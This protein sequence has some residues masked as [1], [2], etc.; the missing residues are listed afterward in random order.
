MTCATALLDLDPFSVRL[1]T[2]SIRSF[3]GGQGEKVVLLHG[4]GGSAANWTEVLDRLVPG[5]R[6]L[7][8]DLPGHGGSDPLP[9]GASVDDYADAVAV[10]IDRRG[11]A[12]A[13]VVGHSFGGQ[14]ALRLAVRHPRLVQALLLVVSSGVASLPRRSAMGGQLTTALRP[15][16]WLAP[17][18][19]RYAGSTWFRM[20][21]FRPFL[22]ADAAAFPPRA[23]LGFFAELREHRDVRGAFRALL[24]DMQGDDVELG[25]P[26]IVVWGA[27]DGIVPVEHG[28][29]LARLLG[30]PLRVVADCGHLVIGER[31]DAVV[32]AIR[33]MLRDQTGFS[34]STNS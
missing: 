19:S 10:A 1:A 12:P 2:G 17:L 32:D 26:A 22:V 15:G 5:H 13:L 20:L 25:C 8:L 7:A 16:R 18:A 24:A 14:V 28:L 9:R 30:A 21:A 27:D 33:S 23:V 4:L 34:T 3:D 6:V 31:P 29:R 11:G